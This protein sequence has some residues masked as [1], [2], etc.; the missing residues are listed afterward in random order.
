M[1]LKGADFRKKA[2]RT[3]KTK[4]RKHK[5]FEVEDLMILKRACPAEY[6]RAQGAFKDSMIH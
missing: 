2:C 4:P 5:V 6:H 3:L 1:N